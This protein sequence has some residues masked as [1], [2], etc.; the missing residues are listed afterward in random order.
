VGGNARAR[1][2]A[3]ELATA[4]ARARALELATAAARVRVSYSCS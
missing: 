3:V 1:A 2:R 4:A